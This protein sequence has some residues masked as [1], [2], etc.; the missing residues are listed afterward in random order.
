LSKELATKGNSPLVTKNKKLIKEYID[1]KHGDE[2]PAIKG[3]LTTIIETK[4]DNPLTIEVL[5]ENFKE[6]Y[7]QSIDYQ[8]LIEDIQS[9]LHKRIGPD[10]SSKVI[11]ISE[12]SIKKRI[13]ESKNNHSRF[14][15]TKDYNEMKLA[16]QDLSKS[17]NELSDI[18]K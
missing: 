9:K 6:K 12:Q 10:I 1:T 7:K 18:F 3:A 17:V 14:N 16:F 4:L 11:G 15:E 8:A 5:R 13:I 2:H